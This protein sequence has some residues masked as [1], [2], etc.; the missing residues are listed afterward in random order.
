[1]IFYAYV[2]S[3]ICILEHCADFKMK[4][5]WFETETEFYNYTV[6]K[7]WVGQFLAHTAAIF[8]ITS[9]A[10]GWNKTSTGVQKT[11]IN[12]VY[13]KCWEVI[14]HFIMNCFP[15]WAVWRKYWISVTFR[16]VADSI[17]RNVNMFLVSFREN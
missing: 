13:W 6:S 2:A 14:E 4:P 10:G 3:V 5:I 12:A 17:Y 1:M 9:N 16:S 8:V 11:G 7:I 15:G